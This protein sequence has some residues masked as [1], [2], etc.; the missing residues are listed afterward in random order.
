M[1]LAPL[2]KRRLSAGEELGGR[3]RPPEIL[4]GFGEK[5]L[6]QED[7]AIGAVSKRSRL[8]REEAV[9]L[10][11][12]ANLKRTGLQSFI[13]SGPID[14]VTRSLRLRGQTGD[15]IRIQA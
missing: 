4:P 11:R 10:E 15:E 5:F 9:K 6:E 13:Q 7:I 3:I 12:I 1:S 8:Q 14:L 2:D